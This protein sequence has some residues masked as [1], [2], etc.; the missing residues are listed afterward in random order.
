MIQESRTF[1]YK[2]TG[3]SFVRRNGMN[4]MG[5]RSAF[6]FTIFGFFLLEAC[7][8]KIKTNVLV[9]AKAHGAAQLNRLAVLPFQGKCGQE[10]TLELESMLVGIKVNDGPYFTVI[11]RQAINKVIS[12]QKFQF[13]GFVDENTAVNVAHLLGA[14]GIIIGK[15]DDCSAEDRRYQ[16]ERS[17]CALTD[18]DGKCLKWRSQNVSCTERVA[19]VY[20]TPKVIDVKSGQVVASEIL[21]GSAG[22]ST[23]SDSGRAVA[24]KNDLLVKARSTAIEK[25]REIV[26][27][28]YVKMEIKLLTSDD[29]KMA[30]EVKKLIE[31]GVEWSNKGRLDRACEQ[32][33]QAGALHGVGYALPYLLGVCA[34]VSG[35]FSKA[36][37]Y[38]R[39]ADMNTGSPVDEISE[40]LGRI[41]LKIDNQRKLQNQ[42]T[43]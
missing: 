40:A 28:H 6:L 16:E 43:R 37:D 11:E 27:P 8:P 31:N 13:G 1:S 36:E 18:K 33:G 3:W 9:P 14:D 38:Y 12:E 15:V 24:G 10:I 39:K 35:N 2:G 41:K 32:W 25:F 7:A 26:A 17:K 22:D 20:F 21:S 19:R 30:P 5:L 23:C 34:E 42:L 29:T 4:L